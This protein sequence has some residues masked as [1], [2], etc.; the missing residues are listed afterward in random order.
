MNQPSPTES[1]SPKLLHPH[2]A[3]KLLRLSVVTIRSYVRDEKIPYIR[4]G[5][6]R[7]PIRFKLEDL[8]EWIDNSHHYPEEVRSDN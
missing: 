6:R 3:A 5:G 4:L 7:G 2:E 8:Q 1:Q